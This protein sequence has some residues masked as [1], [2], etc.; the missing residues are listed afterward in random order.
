MNGISG[1]L[2]RSLE[3]FEVRDVTDSLGSRSTHLPTLVERINIPYNSSSASPGLIQ[4]E[5]V[6]PWSKSGKYA[7]GWVY[8]C[9]LLLVFTIATRLFHIFTDKIRTAMQK[10]GLIHL[11][12]MI[13]FTPDTPH[14]DAP[15]IR[16]SPL[17]NYSPDSPYLATPMGSET[18]M[19]GFV[20]RHTTYT[21]PSSPRI[22]S[23]VSSI[24][25]LNN[26]IAMFR[27]CFYRPTPIFYIHKKIRPITLPSL[28]I[29]AI[30][31]AALVFT[32]LYTFVPQPL[33]WRSIRDG[34]PPVAIRSGMIA[35]AMMPWLVALS[36]KANLVSFLTG[37][38]HERLNVLHRWG[39]W[40]CLFLSLVHTVPFYIMPIWD[41]GGYRIYHT[42]FGTG[43]YIYG[44]G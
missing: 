33:Y 29:L 21:M 10:D 8:F 41:R 24:A 36:M 35:V 30:A 25:P 23:R 43:I 17:L 31:S 42:Y 20:P 3:I 38:G 32:A 14:I 9:I 11:S 2:R 39:G 12:P 22:Q 19:A 44:T 37:I 6:D 1:P 27:W 18:S 34:S 7:L 28:A 5:T 4:A 16:P 15:S 13:G 40:L 26:L